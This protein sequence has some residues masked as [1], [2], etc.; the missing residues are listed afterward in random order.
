MQQAY[1]WLCPTLWDSVV[2]CDVLRGELELGAC[3]VD[4]L[5][6]GPSCASPYTKAETGKALT[7]WLNKAIPATSG[8]PR[9]DIF[10]TLLGADP[11]YG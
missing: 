8:Q 7:A 3:V 11:G 10:R 2:G 9:I 4:P 1:I 6:A 5:R